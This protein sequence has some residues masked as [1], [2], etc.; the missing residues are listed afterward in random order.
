MTE[1]QLLESTISYFNSQNLCVVDG[2]CFYSPISDKTEGCAIGRHLTKKAKK[3]F[4]KCNNGNT[5]IRAVF[6]NESLKKM[7]PKWMQKMDISFLV[8]MQQLHDSKGNWNETGLSPKGKQEV[9]RIMAQ[10]K[11]NETK[12]DQLT[13][14]AKT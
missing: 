6:E 2:G 7:A 11:L 10:F 9:V 12:E 8:N 3:A 5:Q 1:L 13:K 14:G 4:D